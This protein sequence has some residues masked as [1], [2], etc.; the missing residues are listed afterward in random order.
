LTIVAPLSDAKV[1]TAMESGAETRARLARRYPLDEFNAA[2]A[3]LDP[4]GIL[5]SPRLEAILPHP[6]GAAST[7]S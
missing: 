6:R 7:R 2:R 1:N 5:A 3:R 4:K